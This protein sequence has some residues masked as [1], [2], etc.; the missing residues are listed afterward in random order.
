MCGRSPLENNCSFDVFAEIL[1]AHMAR[2]HRIPAVNMARNRLMLVSFQ[3]SKED[4]CHTAPRISGNLSCLDGKLP[5]SLFHISWYRT[6]F[7]RHP[8]INDEDVRERVPEILRPVKCHGP[9]ERRLPHF[10]KPDVAIYAY[11]TG[12]AHFE[13]P[14]VLHV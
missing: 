13:N 2:L 7:L 4:P 10:Q 11:P 12:V 1:T 3:L 8:H 6:P 9:S 5:M 14:P